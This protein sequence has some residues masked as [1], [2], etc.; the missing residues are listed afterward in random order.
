LLRLAQQRLTDRFWQL[1][2]AVAPVMERW[3]RREVDD[4][5][6]ADGVLKAVIEG[7]TGDNAAGEG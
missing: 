2:D 3:S 5:E 6:A 4:R 7:R 1:S